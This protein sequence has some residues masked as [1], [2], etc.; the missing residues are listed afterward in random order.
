MHLMI[1]VHRKMH[2][3]IIRASRNEKDRVDQEKKIKDSL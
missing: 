1:E 3:I 2:E